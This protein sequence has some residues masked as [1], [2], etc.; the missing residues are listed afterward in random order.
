MPDYSNSKI[1]SIE[2]NKTGLV[3][4]GSTTAPTLARRLAEHRSNFKNG[5]RITKITFQ[6]S[7]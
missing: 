2:C 4:I 6:V 5:K 7:K 3:Y 1:Y